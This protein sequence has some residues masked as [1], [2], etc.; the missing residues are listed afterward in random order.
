MNLQT[1]WEEAMWMY[2]KIMTLICLAI[3]IF[4][5]NEEYKNGKMS[6]RNFKIVCVCEGVAFMGM[7]YRILMEL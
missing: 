5:C 2:I 6:A 4:L 1:G 7:V 3:T